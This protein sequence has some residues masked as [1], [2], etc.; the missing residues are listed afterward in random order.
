MAVD[1]NQADQ[2]GQTPL[3]TAAYVG[4]DVIVQLLLAH[5]DVDV[6]KAGQALG[7]TPLYIAAQ[8]GLDMAVQL[9]LAH[10][11]IKVEQASHKG[12]TPLLVA[13]LANST[14]AALAL[15]DA[16]ADP[17]RQWGTTS[18]S[19]P[20]H[21]AHQA[22][23]TELLAAL[24]AAGGD[25]TVL[26]APLV[27]KCMLGDAHAARGLLLE[28]PMP[29]PSGA[30][31]GAEADGLP[32][33]VLACLRGDVAAILKHDDST[34]DDDCP[35]ACEAHADGMQPAFY[36][37]VELGDAAVVAATLTGA[38]SS[39]NER[40][41]AV[42]CE[43]VA[44]AAN[45]HDADASNYV[46]GTVPSAHN[47]TSKYADHGI[48]P[49]RPPTPSPCCPQAHGTWLRFSPWHGRG[50]STWPCAVRS[51]RSLPATSVRLLWRDT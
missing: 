33:L 13:C 36:F 29:E 30:T 11:A 12:T 24:V 28:T 5:E 8:L 40:Q 45:T 41:I 50:S 39:L 3:F 2:R 6:N 46:P 19:T 15:L 9:L 21:L 1:P 20:L 42:L 7:R 16:K 35:D 44:L 37:A 4:N 49:S 51:S 31:S 10:P 23:N 34:P 22:D 32:P 17:N 14:A 18:D 25:V 47:H 38:Q 48:A 26:Y 43:Q 27:A